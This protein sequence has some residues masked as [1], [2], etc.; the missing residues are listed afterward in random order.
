MF[1]FLA[2]RRNPT[3]W[4]YIWP[5]DQTQEDHRTLIEQARKDP[6]AVILIAEKTEMK[7]YAPLIFDYIEKEYVIAAETAELTLYIPLHKR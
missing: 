1:Y 7:K 2:E 6:P 5:G 3:K 4:N